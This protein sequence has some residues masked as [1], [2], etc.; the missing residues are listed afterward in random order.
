MN[1]ILI[2]GGCGFIGT[3]C[4]SKLI[5]QNN[6]Y[7]IIVLDNLSTGTPKDLSEVT[8]YCILEK[9]SNPPISEGVYLLQADIRDIESLVKFSEGIDCIVHLAANTGVGPSIED[10]A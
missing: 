1:N 9:S 6:S 7:R 10:L 2:T 5:A 4:I 3:S 8:N